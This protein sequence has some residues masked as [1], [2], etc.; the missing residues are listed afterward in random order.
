M[1]KKIKNSIIATV[2][3]IAI[4]ILSIVLFDSFVKGDGADMSTIPSGD[5]LWM[6]C[7]KC[8]FTYQMPARDY[9]QYVQDNYGPFVA[10]RPLP[11]ESCGEKCGYKSLKCNKCEAVFFEVLRSDGY[12]DRCTECGF[13]EKES[14]IR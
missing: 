2:S 14:G 12:A 13:S 6:K 9:W 5:Q 4:L 7:S 10:N 8:Q 11:C 3:V 1:E